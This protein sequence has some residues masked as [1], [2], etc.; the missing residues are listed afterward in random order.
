MSEVFY[1]K[2]RGCFVE[3]SD[4]CVSGR[5]LMPR[6]Q[7]IKEVSK[8]QLVTAL[9]N[10]KRRKTLEGKTKCA[11]VVVLLKREELLVKLN[12]YGCLVD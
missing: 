7:L 8:E 12:K 11:K 10:N 3:E 1:E 9:G 5:G 2:C 4:D 6:P